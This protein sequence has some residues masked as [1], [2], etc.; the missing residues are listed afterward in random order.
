MKRIF[1]DDQIRTIK[2]IP[3]L[4]LLAS[5]AQAQNLTAAQA[6]AHEGENATV[7]GTVASEYHRSE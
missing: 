6:K 5:V 4:L 1:K 2:F 3:A 7:C